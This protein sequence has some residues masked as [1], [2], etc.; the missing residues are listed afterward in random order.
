VYVQLREQFW[1][2]HLIREATFEEQHSIV[3]QNVLRLGMILFI[4][5]E[6]MFFFAFFWAF[7]HERNSSTLFKK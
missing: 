6:I 1:L 2:T 5:S 7:F 4:I 3:V